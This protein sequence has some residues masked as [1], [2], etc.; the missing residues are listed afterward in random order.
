MMMMMMMIIMNFDDCLGSLV[1]CL[2]AALEDGLL[3]ATAANLNNKVGKERN[4]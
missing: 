4:G 3:S 2:V 1:L